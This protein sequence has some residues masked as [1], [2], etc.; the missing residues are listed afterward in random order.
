M[1]R[2][3]IKKGDNLIV[4]YALKWI[5]LF[6]DGQRHMA[7]SSGERMEAS[8]EALKRVEAHASK[9]HQ[10]DYT[11]CSIPKQGGVEDEVI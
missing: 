2:S 6:Q 3:H 1:K 4:G 10:T 7:R 5:P 11:Q 9:G 8:R